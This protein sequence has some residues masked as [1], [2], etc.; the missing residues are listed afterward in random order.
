MLNVEWNTGVGSRESAVGEKGCPPTPDP[1]L[2]TPGY[3]TLLLLTTLLTLTSCITVTPRTQHTSPTA[4]VIPNVPEQHW[5]IESCGAGSLSTVLQHYGDTT[6]M[7]SWDATLPK[8]RGGVLTIDMLIAARKAGFD[9]Q[10]V[11]GS[12]A[13]IESELQQGRPVI[14][15][16]Q[17][18]DSPGH[19]YDFF[20]YIVADGIDPA[21]GLVRMQFGDGKGRWTTFDRLE[22]AWAGGGHAAILIHPAGVSDALR[23]AVALEDAGKY[24]EAAD[25]YRA[26]LARHPDSLVALTNLGNAEMQLGNRAEAEDAFR[27]VLARDATSRDALNNLAWLLYESKR[28]DEAESLARKAVAQRGPDSYLVLDTLARVLTAKGSCDEA[29]TT[30]RAAIDAVPPARTS[31]RGDLEKAMAEAQTSCRSAVAG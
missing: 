10:L 5:G 27:K 9:A 12:P 11:T 22:K 8:T 7:Q 21:G 14:L 16:L 28:Y 13:I 4:A 15:M 3:S 25:A 20:H 18:V 6:T 30:F 31:A 1:R 2:P 26:I 24:A 17:V 19:H 23:D 29:L